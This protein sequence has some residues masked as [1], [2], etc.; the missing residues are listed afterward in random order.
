[1]NKK[2]LALLM[3]LM[4]VIS[5]LPLAAAAEGSCTE[6][7]TPG[8]EGYD[9]HL[10]SVC[11]EHVSQ[12]EDRDNN[13]LCE[14]CGNDTHMGTSES[15]AEG[16]RFACNNC[17]YAG[18][19][20]AHYDT[21]GDA[22]C[23]WCN[24]GCQHT[25]VAWNNSANGH[26]SNCATCGIEISE[27]EDHTMVNNA[28]TTCGYTPCTGAHT[29]GTEGYE[30]HICQICS[31]NTDCVDDDMDCVCDICGGSCH[32]FYSHTESNETQ[33]RSVCSNCGYA[34]PWEN[35]FDHNHDTACDNC[36]YGC[37]HSSGSEWYYNQDGHSC[38]CSA[39]Y[40]NVVE[41]E[42][43]TMDGNVCTVCGYSA[44]EGEHTFG[45]E[46]WE[47]HR[48]QV[49]GFQSYCEDLNNDCVCDIC[50][51]TYHNTD[52]ESSEAGHRWVC[53]NCDVAYD[54][55]DHTDPQGLGFCDY[56]GYGCDHNAEHE[57]A[58]DEELH[59]KYCTKCYYYIADAEEHSFVDDVCTVCGYEI[60][61]EIPLPK[62][63]DPTIL[64]MG[65]TLSLA[66]ATAFVS[67]KKEN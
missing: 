52:I 28:C 31:F 63:G 6:G 24:Y 14:I 8:T 23:D 32:Y 53:V 21:N 35:H 57:W 4:L 62:D 29:F 19:W 18:E 51:E 50:G 25:T 1:M 61:G 47:V 2:F 48:C 44:C 17:D 45:T 11:G 16:H 41:W 12:C 5:V 56:C 38:W 39:C 15:S 9:K 22:A 59:R 46:G 54:W 55:E 27:W 66:C 49:C 42:D 60:D 13:C 43:H 37:D 64:V 20:E 26:W 7:H 3:A 34:T 58:F 33:H 36:G 30:K 67:K 10:C 65:I 40:Q